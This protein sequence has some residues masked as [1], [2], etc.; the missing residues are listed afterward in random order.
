MNLFDNFLIRAAGH[1]FF[2]FDLTRLTRPLSVLAPAVPKCLGI[3][4]GKFR[5]AKAELLILRT[6]FCLPDLRLYS[7]QVVWLMDLADWA[8]DLWIARLEIGLNKGI[9]DI[10]QAARALL[11]NKLSK[12]IEEYR[13]L[14]TEE[15]IPDGLEGSCEVLAEN[16]A[17]LQGNWL[18]VGSVVAHIP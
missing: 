4:T 5:A 15:N 6:A 9:Q 7:R 10:Q 17:R 14:W 12:L 11:A 3:H 2:G 13:S 1:M 18:G 8:C 16:L